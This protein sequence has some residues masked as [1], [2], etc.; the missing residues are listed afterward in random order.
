MTLRREAGRSSIWML[1]GNA[2]QQVFGFLV[3]IYLARILTPADFGTIALAYV[4]TDTLTQIGR[5]GQ[6]EALQQRA[7]LSHETASTA[8]WLLQGMGLLFSVLVVLLAE[9]AERLF[10]APHLADVLYLLAPVCFLQCLGGVHEAWLRRSFGYRAL[11]T[12]TFVAALAGS[13]VA[14]ALAT[15]GFGLYAL[16]A[17]RLVVVAVLT[18]LVFVSYRWVPGL[19]FQRG[20]ARKLLR[21]GFDV[22]TAT[23]MNMIGPRIV[24]GIVGLFLGVVLLGQLRIAWRIVDF[25]NQLTFQPVVS[26][27]LSSLSR[28]Q[29]DRDAV[30]RAFLRFVQISALATIPVFVGLALVA[31]DL[32]ALLLGPQWG[33]AVPLFRI[34]ALVSLAAPVNFFFAPTLIAVGETATVLRQALLQLVLT[35]GLATLAAQ[36]G[37][38]SVLA[39]HVLRSYIV[40]GFNVAALKRHAGLAFSQLFHAL[41]PPTAGAAVMA[42]AV[43]GRQLA[44]PG[45]E[46]WAG[47]SCDVVV[48]ALVY[49]A[50]LLGGDFAHL[51]PRHIR[52]LAGLVSDILRRNP[53]IAGKAS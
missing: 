10:A 26:V 14:A 13:V 22:T 44:L 36:I 32:F 51:W 12:R 53:A 39:A 7:E 2:G 18:A 5:L 1:A 34:L 40:A 6:V 11:A 24:D 43:L 47:L 29:A 4:V 48:G 30:R 8:F 15:Y 19:H 21:T 23:V 28:L 31:D 27:A 49:A 3:F 41:L 16:A 35:V 45:L 46:A 52:G 37:L 38:R 33:A 17:Q 42:V 9:P 50:V 20:E 25:I